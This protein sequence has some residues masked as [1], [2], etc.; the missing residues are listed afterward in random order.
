VHL[1]VQDVW[2][3]I[4]PTDEDNWTFATLAGSLG[5]Y[6]QLADENGANTGAAASSTA[7]NLQSTKLDNTGVNANQL[8]TLMGTDVVMKINGDATSSGTPVLRITDNGN[9]V[10]LPATSSTLANADIGV[11]TDVQAISFVETGPTTGIFTSYDDDDNS[12]LKTEDDAKR[13]TSATITYND[14]SKSVV[15]A[16]SFATL[17]FETNDETWNSGEEI[18]VILTDAD[19]N[20]NSRTDEDITL[21]DSTYTLIPALQTG[22]PFTIGEGNA[23]SGT[24][25]LHLAG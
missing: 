19:I 8:T 7:I 16:N 10:Y 5:T 23:T 21:Y 6:Y 20:K 17:E 14:S 12:A 1:T 11:V 24:F 13:G 2:L 25:A 15:I 4:D 22:D 9:A 18:G 3:N